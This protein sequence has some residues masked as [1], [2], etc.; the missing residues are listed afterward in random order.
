MRFEGLQMKA[1]FNRKTFNDVRYCHKKSLILLF[2]T[3]TNK[4]FGQ[5]QSW[6]IVSTLFLARKVYSNHTSQSTCNRGLKVGVIR[7]FLADW[8][9]PFKMKM[10]IGYKIA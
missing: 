5:E 3:I 8:F 2:E 4:L 10:L 6:L 1:S 7:C 9:Y